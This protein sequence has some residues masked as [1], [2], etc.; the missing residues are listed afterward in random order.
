MIVLDVVITSLNLLR[1]TMK[2]LSQVSKL[3]ACNQALYILPYMEASCKCMVM[4]LS[5]FFKLF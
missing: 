2:N 5:W 4:A 3:P 1:K